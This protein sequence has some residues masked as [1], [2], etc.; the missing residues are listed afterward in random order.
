MDEQGDDAHDSMATR[1]G[2]SMRLVPLR[3]HAICAF[4]ASVYSTWAV[5]VLE[6]GLLCGGNER[7]IGERV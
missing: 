6:T 7:E 5:F 2:L 4:P 1:M 3:A